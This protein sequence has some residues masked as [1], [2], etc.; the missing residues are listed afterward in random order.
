MAQRSARAS[1]HLI[2]HTPISHIRYQQL[3]TRSKRQRGLRPVLDAAAYLSC[4][5]LT[6]VLLF[7]GDAP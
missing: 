3:I 1:A 5:F 7:L 2:E 6:L 4:V